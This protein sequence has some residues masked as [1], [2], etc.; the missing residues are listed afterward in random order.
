[1]AQTVGELQI[2][3]SA[4]M[5][6]LSNDMRQ[7]KGM[8]GSTMSS[9]SRSVAVATSVLGALGLGLGVAMFARMVKGSLEA[10]DQL[11][12]MSQKVGVSVEA[13]AG[14]K[15]A[16]ELSGFGIESLQKGLKTLASQ[17]FD[18]QSGLLESKRNFSSLGLEITNTDGTLKATDKLMVEVADKFAKMNDGALKTALA[19][20]LFGKAGLDLIPMLNQGSAALA[21]MIAEGQ[22]LNPV[23]TESAKQA[24]IFN[25]QMSRV[26]KT[27]QALGVS[28]A[29]DVLPWVSDVSSAMAEA[30]KESGVL[31]AAWVGL[32]GAFAAML[33]I[34]DAQKVKQRLAE[35]NEAIAVGQKQLATG[36]VNPEGAK[37]FFA[38]LP[39]IKLTE[40]RRAKIIEALKAIEVEKKA[41]LAP[42]LAEAAAAALK[43][44]T[45]RAAEA[46][47]ARKAAA[48]DATKKS[49]AAIG[50]AQAERQRLAVIGAQAEVDLA[51]QTAQETAEAWDKW[52]KIQ[53]D[54]EKV[55][56]DAKTEMWRQV[57]DE[58]DAAQEREIEQGR[59][60]LE[61]NEKATD[62][63][64][65]FW[66]SA[67]QSMQRSMSDFFFDIMQGNLKNLGASFKRT[68]DRMVSDN[69]AAQAATSLF[70]KDFAKGGAIG[71]LLGKG[72]DFVKG[73]IPFE[74][75]TDFVPR[76]GPALVHKGEK[77]I[78]AKENARGGE[79]GS[80][81]LIQNYSFGSDVNRATLS[82][83]GR[84]IGQQTL[85]AV[86]DMPRRGG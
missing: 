63:I 51:D 55:R 42:G 3:M 1:M 17:M 67:A 45:A 76:T 5:A 52:G 81:T 38:G 62:E 9:I 12:K 50:K 60:F 13:L 58:I 28:L 6:R 30:A 29:V 69:L 49:A 22:R 86:R 10:Q 85:A 72:V 25:D 20:K 80:V 16:A 27:G 74:H 18:A 41:I 4:N 21:E 43:T 79:A 39:S 19:V 56:V 75:G 83:W 59:L 54:Q 47:A 44:A 31:T 82:Q 11:S 68:I 71:G 14:L 57:F 40:E 26:V 34:T 15:H 23:T 7:A 36:L 61:A 78:S 77:I 65:E 73:L 84:I 35:I 8:V 24:E 53:F 2:V 46:D 66:R 37:G 70:G 33:G 32:G 64:T 48:E